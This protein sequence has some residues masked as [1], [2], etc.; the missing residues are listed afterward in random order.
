M[1]LDR[2]LVSCRNLKDIQRLEEWNIIFEGS[3]QTGLKAP[4]SMDVAGTLFDTFQGLHGLHLNL[5]LVLPAHPFLCEPC[6][7]HCPDF[8]S[9]HKKHSCGVAANYN[10]FNVL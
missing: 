8:D 1:W 5:S 2:S 9:M 6:K 4:R 10:T 7:L 3:R